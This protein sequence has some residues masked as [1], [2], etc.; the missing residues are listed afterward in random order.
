MPGTALAEDFGVRFYF[1]ATG[2]YRLE[3]GAF[4]LEFEVKGYTITFRLNI[5][6]NGPSLSSKLIN[7][8]TAPPF[9]LIL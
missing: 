2:G 9:R 5:I 6:L 7:F 4:A 1:Q 3:D 8:A